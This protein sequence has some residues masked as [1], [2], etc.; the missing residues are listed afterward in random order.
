MTKKQIKEFLKRLE[1][2]EG[3]NFKEEIK[4]DPNSVTWKCDGRTHTISRKILTKMRITKNEQNSFLNEC[5]S[6]GG[7]CD[8]EILFNS[9]EHLL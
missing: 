8:C 4:G 1:G 5:E 9:A 6:S 2:K 3:C 7:H